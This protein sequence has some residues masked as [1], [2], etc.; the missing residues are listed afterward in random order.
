MYAKWTTSP[1]SRST[2]SSSLPMAEAHGGGA[3]SAVAAVDT[4][5]RRSEGGGGGGGPNGDG[6]VKEGEG[7]AERRRRTGKT[8]TD[9]TTFDAR[10]T[11]AEDRDR[12]RKRHL[13]EELQRL[14]EELRDLGERGVHGGGGAG[15][16]GVR[17]GRDGDGR[18]ASTTRARGGGDDGD[19]RRGGVRGADAEQRTLLRTWRCR[20]ACCQAWS[21]PCR[22]TCHKCGA[23]KP[24]NPVRRDDWWIT[25]RLPPWAAE[26]AAGVDAGGGSLERARQPR[27]PGLP[28]PAARRNG[29]GTRAQQ[30]TRSGL[31]ADPRR[32]APGTL[33]HLWP[34]LGG[35]TVDADD[36]D[37]I[38]DTMDDDASDDGGQ[39]LLAARRGRDLGRGTTA[40]A[41]ASD[42]Q[43][44][45]EAAKAPRPSDL[46]P[47]RIFEA[48]SAPRQ[49]LVHR[50][51]ARLGKVERMQAA[52]A[53]PAKIQRAI[54]EKDQLAEK[55]RN[56]GGVTQK[57]LS[58]S[59]K[60]EDD[61]LE[62]AE[63]AIQRAVEE[64]REKAEAIQ[65]LV[66][67]MQG[68]DARIE[69][70]ESRK[71]AAA[72]R[73][74]YLA[75][76]KW[77]ESATGGTVEGYKLLRDSLSSQ[78][79]V[80]APARAEFQ[81]LIDLMSPP[82]HTVD[83]DDG[84]TDSDDD[85]G[86]E[87]SNVTKEETGENAPHAG[88]W[89]SKYR[90]QLDAARRELDRLHKERRSALDAAD[91]WQRRS[92]AKRHLGEDSNKT[93]DQDGDQ[94]M[95]AP[96]SAEQ[97]E[98][99]YHTRIAQATSDIEHL[100]RMAKIEELAPGR[101]QLATKGEGATAATDLATA[102][103]TT[104]AAETTPTA[105]TPA[106]APRGRSPTRAARSRAPT[107]RRLPHP[108][109]GRSPRTE[110]IEQQERMQRVQE[111]EMARLAAAAA[112]AREI[113]AA[114]IQREAAQRAPTPEVD[115]HMAAESADGQALQ[116]APAGEGALVRT[117]VR[118]RT[119]WSDDDE[120]QAG[121]GRERSPRPFPAPRH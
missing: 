52:G 5:G 53:K 72:E 34:R 13:R 49:V 109:G 9:S 76:Q 23:S 116:D 36:D 63:R 33:D 22:R 15:G 18:M 65:R 14:G 64:K 62:R 113:E 106:S 45:P 29:G 92:S 83:I 20:V 114:V 82:V 38:D 21:W 80:L 94:E 58:Y 37:L 91:V 4:A 16:G 102:A 68:I 61:K 97:V 112:T 77:A 35:G 96:L 85:D 19:G 89:V 17:R 95:V 86:G 42:A 74:E 117:A 12:E 84:D 71:K 73:R 56:A 99:H 66:D 27:V 60:G 107:P 87:S 55:V 43:R 101:E 88:T 47:V 78:D 93:Q 48:P 7:P 1:T 41:A 11:T 10:C 40:K 26:E 25:S 54:E 110:E 50:Y 30:A 90:L 111:L 2:S 119:R 69:R 31:E 6:R 121:L 32:T 67:E 8:G 44:H 98:A 108:S 115:V 24:V 57:S 100:E 46:P 28:P 104:A 39:W 118:R 3:Q 81:R 105:A 79:P 75:K 103:T 70:L 120:Q 51:Q 59:I